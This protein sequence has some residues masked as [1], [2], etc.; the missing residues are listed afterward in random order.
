MARECALYIYYIIF[1]LY[2]RYRIAQIWRGAGIVLLMDG[3]LRFLR[4]WRDMV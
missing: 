1:F 4:F 2:I 3:C